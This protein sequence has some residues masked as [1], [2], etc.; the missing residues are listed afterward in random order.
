MGGSRVSEVMGDQ[1]CQG[2]VP[3]TKLD[4]PFPGPKLAFGK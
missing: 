3:E 4:V 2:F 1:R